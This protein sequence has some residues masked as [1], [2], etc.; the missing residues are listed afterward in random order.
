MP[1][2]RPVARGLVLGAAGLGGLAVLWLLLPGP[3]RRGGP[4]PVGD[5]AARVCPPDAGPAASPPS[6]RRAARGPV[7]RTPP[8]ARSPR[9]WPQ[10]GR[11]PWQGLDLPPPAPPAPGELP[12]ERPAL[13]TPSQEITVA[14]YEAALELLRDAQS[15]TEQALAEHVRAGD[16]ELAHRARVRLGRLALAQER[17]AEELERARGG[18]PQPHARDAPDTVV[19]PP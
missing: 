8:D 15:R 11:A 12:A 13:P 3:G 6:Q 1:R 18:E 5:P 19:E 7:E 4:P 10:P 2:S 16:D 9:Q 17:R 14:R